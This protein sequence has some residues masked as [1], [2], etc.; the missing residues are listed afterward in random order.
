MLNMQTW[1]ILTAAPQ[2]AWGQCQSLA[3]ASGGARACFGRDADPLERLMA[4][5]PC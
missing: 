4:K 1:K 2:A 3:G 5:P